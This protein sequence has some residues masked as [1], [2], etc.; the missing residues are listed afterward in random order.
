MVMVYREFYLAPTDKALELTFNV[1]YAD[2]E[3]GKKPWNDGRIIMH[4]KDADGKKVGPNPGAPAFKGTSD[5]WKTVSRKFLV[6]D[7]A[8]KM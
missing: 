4:F 7:A 1:R 6:P 3:K 2:I 8:V 5:S